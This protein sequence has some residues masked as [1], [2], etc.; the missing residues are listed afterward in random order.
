MSAPELNADV[1]HA[2]C[3][4]AKGPG[5][6]LIS[7]RILVRDVSVFSQATGGA[8][9]AC[10]EHHPH[11]G[12]VA[13]SVSGVSQEDLSGTVAVVTGGGRG[14]GRAI[15]LSLARAGAAVAISGR[16]N[17]EL[18]NTLSELRAIHHRTL[19]ICC[20]VTYRAAVDEMVRRTEA[21]LGPIDFLVNNAGSPG[22]I[23][24]LWETDPDDWWRTIE[25][26]LRGP[27][28]CARSVLPGM[29]ARR[30]GR[31][32]N[33]ASAA[34][35]KPLPYNSTYACSKA[36]LV[37]LTDSLQQEAAQYGV[38]VFATSPG[39]VRT[40]MTDTL[41]SSEA[42]RKWIPQFSPE[43]PDYDKLPW[44]PPEQIADLCVRLARG[45]GDAL[46][47]RFIHVLYDFDDM[48][49]RASNVMRDDLYQLRLHTLPPK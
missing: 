28:L 42:A 33:M 38:V 3:Y 39:L 36:A 14:I 19:A 23:G 45:D 30:R 18:D 20:D 1:S 12:V 11:E 2:P 27:M 49:T 29:I 41:G 35:L 16:S 48:R 8:I 13:M 40:S 22:V 6:D 44:S 21:E 37:R 32:V 47:G 43:H 24:P 17:S 34:G 31:I 5:T 26:N 15:G 7:F 4:V 9:N 10:A 46:A 25:V